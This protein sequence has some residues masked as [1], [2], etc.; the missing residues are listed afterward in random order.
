M[1]YVLMN[2]ARNSRTF[3]FCHMTFIFVAVGVE[4]TLDMRVDLKQQ[5]EEPM[6]R[7]DQVCLPT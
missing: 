6:G 5:P 7:N 1:T 2:S 4:T 3:S